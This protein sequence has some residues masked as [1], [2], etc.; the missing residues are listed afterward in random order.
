MP[1]RTTYYK[2]ICIDSG[3]GG[4]VSNIAAVYDDYQLLL[5]SSLDFLPIGLLHVHAI[6]FAGDRL[7][8]K[9]NQLIEV[10]PTSLKIRSKMDGG[11]FYNQIQSGS[12]QHR[13][14]AAAFRLQLGPEWIS[15]FWAANFGEPGKFQL[16]VGDRQLMD[17]CAR[18]AT[19]KYH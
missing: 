10:L 11:K 17:D 15:K 18:K 3:S 16:Q 7:V 14:K 9:S 8:A 13:C 2:Y 19:E 5:F 6:E 12:F 4:V 1:Y